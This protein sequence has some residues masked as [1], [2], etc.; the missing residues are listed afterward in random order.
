MNVT[1]QRRP[2]L[3]LK[4]R[5]LERNFTLHY[6]DKDITQIESSWKL[7]VYVMLKSNLHNVLWWSCGFCAQKWCFNLETRSQGL[8]RWRY[9]M[10]N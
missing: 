6:E 9:N 2:E 4:K 5:R 3:T 10:S 8:L 1:G 7:Y